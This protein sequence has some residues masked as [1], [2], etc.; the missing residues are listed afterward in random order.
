[1]KKEE[2][3]AQISEYLDKRGIKRTWLADEIGKSPT[4]ITMMLDGTLA[5]TDSNLRKINIALF[6]EDKEKY[7]NR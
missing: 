6:E 1:M 7:F 5:I 3:R 4:L 2:L